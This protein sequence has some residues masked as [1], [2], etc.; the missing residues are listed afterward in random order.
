M[1]TPRIQFSLRAFLASIALIACCLGW[2]KIGV[3]V[4]CVMLVIAAT[5]RLLY[6]RVPQDR[7]SLSLRAGTLALT[8]A[9]L[10]LGSFAA[11]RVFRTYEF[12]LMPADD[13]QS[14]LV[15]FS[16]EPPVQQFAL[17]LYSPL[18]G[19]FPGHCHYPSRD[20]IQVLNRDPFT[21]ARITLF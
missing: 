8:L 11:F 15:I 16:L 18:I 14:N 19:L 9:A 5:A 1:G 17:V 13:P 10:Y 4:T 2:A 20:E 21:G 12:S 6:L 3:A 7:R